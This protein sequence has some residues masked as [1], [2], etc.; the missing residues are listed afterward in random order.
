MIKHLALV[1]ALVLLSPLAWGQSIILWKAANS[2]SATVVPTYSGQPSPFPQVKAKVEEVSST[3]DVEAEALRIARLQALH[4]AEQ[5]LNSKSAFQPQLQGLQMGGRVDGA[6]GPKVL[7]YNQWMG[8]GSQ[9]RVALARTQNADA[10]LDELR[11]YD[12][13]AANLLEN[14]L[15]K[16]LEAN[17][18]L[19]LTII[20]I[21]PKIVEFKS[22]YGLHRLSIPG[23]E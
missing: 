5:I 9:V 15:N 1:A 22:I 12:S 23:V 3:L 4:Q 10:A 7:I 2:T 21:H 6:A 13:D 18:T 17:P 8:V 19:D 14:K 20:A 11:K 16:R